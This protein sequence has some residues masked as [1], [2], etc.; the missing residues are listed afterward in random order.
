[1]K[2][3]ICYAKDHHGLPIFEYGLSENSSLL[4]EFKNENAQSVSF[5]VDTDKEE[6]MSEDAYLEVISHIENNA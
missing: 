2:V 5:S 1:M 4:V 6:F 3:F